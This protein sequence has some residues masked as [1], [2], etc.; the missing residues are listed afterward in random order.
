MLVSKDGRETPVADS[1]APIK[2]ETGEI[3]G[4]VLVFRDQ[5]EERKAQRALQEAREFAV[6]VVETVREPLA[7]LDGSLKVIS[8]NRSFYDTFKTTSGE[9][10][11]VCICDLGNK[12]WEIPKL[13]ELLEKILPENATFEDFEVEHDFPIIGR[14]I[15]MLNARRIYREANKTEMILLAIEDI[16]ERKRVEEALNVSELRYRR[17]FETA[18][19]GILILD[20]ETGMIIDVNPFLM[21]LLRFSHEQF[22]GKAIWEVGLLKDIASNK[23]KFTELQRQ[24]YVRYEDLPLETADGRRIEVEFI[25]N[26]YTVDR[27]KVVQ[28]NIRDITERKRTERE[29]EEKLRQTIKMKLDF[30]SMVSHELRT[31]LTVIKEGIALAADGSA[32]EIN[33]EQKELLGLSRRNVDRLAKF[34]N[35]VLDFQK[36]EADRMKMDVQPNDIN[37]I[38]RNVYRT[39]T[40]AAK[41][42]GVNLLLE[43]DD[44]LPIVGFD[45]DKITQVLTNLVDNAVK[46]TEKGNIVIK[47]SE[48]NGMIHVSVSDTG[49][50]IKKKDLSRLFRMF[51][52]LSTGGER[53]TG[54][55]GLGLAICKG[56]IERHNGK[57]WVDSV[58]GKGSKF[59]FTLPICNAK[60]IIR[61]Y[62]NDGIK[63][64]STNNMRMSL[65]LISID[66]LD[67]L[68]Q[69]LSPERINSTLK[70]MEAILEN[71][72]HRRNSRPNQ[73]TDAVYRFSNEF[74][75]VLTNCGKENVQVVKERLEQ[76]L[77]DYLARKDLAAKIRLF[78]GCVTYP[79]DAVTSEGLIEKAEELHPVVSTALSV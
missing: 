59:T 27:Q 16:T 57:I 29:L 41:N 19:D 62:I 46:F 39:M 30:I 31:P 40:L 61:E 70:H 4:M 37:E 66:D 3:I 10:E 14:R 2:S 54:G 79:D 45:N 38:A 28:C 64:A 63:E 73:V 55:T 72:L 49:C 34:I 7:I 78:L 48:K 56:I 23:H 9:A 12:Q 5:T 36:L 1:G 47:T 15:M 32:G 17:L 11:G 52:Q 35:E 43:L 44:R 51:E 65:V 60:E 58:F 8:A 18:R 77:N 75:I 20:A 13:R 69:K 67:E 6:N 68:K 74:F 50:G 76:K 42:I 22:A 53:K 24:K 21:E 33:E 25:S 71:D 26:V